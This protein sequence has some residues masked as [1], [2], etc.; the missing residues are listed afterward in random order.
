M[1]ALGNYQV[2]NAVGG[3]ILLA[4]TRSEA[5]KFLGLR[6][7]VG[8]VSAGIFVT[9][10][11][12]WLLGASAKASG[13][14]GFDTAMPAPLLVFATLQMGQLFFATAAVLHITSEYSSGIVASTQ[15]AVPRRSIVLR[16]KALFLAGINFI[17][18]LVMIPLASI[19]TA[20]SA[21]E[22]EA[23]VF[24][25]LAAATLGAATYLSLL[26]LMTL[27]LGLLCRNSAGAIVLAI[28]LVVGLP[29]I[30]QLIPLD[31]VHTLTQYLPTNAATFMATGTTEPYGPPGALAVFIA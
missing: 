23:F 27:G 7:V 3:S 11:F 28:L 18:G 22:Y 31:W 6:T 17:V 14:N 19:P 25:D 21:G 15:Q 1:S 16:S 2:R 29:Q 10:A 8:L 24:A 20:L 9:I 4:A 26:S 13:D 5:T 12:G 30:L